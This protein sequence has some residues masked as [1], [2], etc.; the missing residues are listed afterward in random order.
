MITADSITS[1]N[2]PE[3]PK[4]AGTFY[5]GKKLIKSPDKERDDDMPT[6]KKELGKL[7]R[8]KKEKAEELAKLVAEGSQ[9][10]KKKLKKLEKK[11]K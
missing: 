11:I 9:A 3:W 10:A 2:N 5:E 1:L 6:S 7:N 4:T 8:A